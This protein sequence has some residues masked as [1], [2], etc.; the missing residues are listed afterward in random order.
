MT[1]TVVGAL[2]LGVSVLDVGGSPAPPEPVAQTRPPDV[3][4]SGPSATD[5]PAEPDAVAEPSPTPLA[6]PEEPDPQQPVPAGQVSESATG[7]LTAV[8]GTDPPSDSAGRVVS[9]RVVVEDGLTVAGEP[10]DGAQVAAIVHEVLTDPRGWEGV[11]GV[12][13][14]RVAEQPAEL[15]VVLASPATVDRLCAP[16]RTGG[17]LSCYNGSATALNAR[18]WFAGSDLFGEDLVSYR[19]YLIYHEVGH[20]LGFGHVGCPAPGAPAPVMM[21]QTKGLDGCTANA[22]PAVA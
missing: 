13:F 20:H 12:R 15:D 17:W 8:P 10:V 11:L 9:Y 21:Q 5:P 14:G 4:A 16:L 1:L 22:W 6:L 3:P 18:R 7:T 2:F 19:H